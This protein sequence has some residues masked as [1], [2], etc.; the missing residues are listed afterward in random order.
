MSI[1]LGIAGVS[2]AYVVIHPVSM[3]TEGICWFVVDYVHMQSGMSIIIYSRKVQCQSGSALPTKENDQTQ[4][5]PPSPKRGQLHPKIILE[6]C[7][8]KQDC[9]WR[10]ISMSTA[11]FFAS[12]L[13]LYLILTARMLF[14][15]NQWRILY[16]IIIIRRRTI[17]PTMKKG[18]VC[19]T[20]FASRKFGSHSQTYCKVK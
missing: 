8:Y 18:D 7:F 6:P 5:E 15:L 14:S 1:W 12:Q 11:T 17:I 2:W 9:A 13:Q 16:L 19:F 20:C 4:M 3:V 10:W